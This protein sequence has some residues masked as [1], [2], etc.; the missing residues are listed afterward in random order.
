MLRSFLHH[1][2]GELWCRDVPDADGGYTFSCSIVPSAVNFLVP[3]N[4]YRKILYFKDLWICLES[5]KIGMDLKLKKFKVVFDHSVQKSVFFGIHDLL[6][7]MFIKI[8]D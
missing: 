5:G 6:F 7:R 3:G 2:G 8:I 4:F 1:A